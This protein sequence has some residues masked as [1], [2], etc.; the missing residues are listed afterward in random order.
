[1][2]GSAR[3]AVHRRLM[4]R[5]AATVGAETGRLDAAA[6]AAAVERCCTCGHVGAC[7]DWLEDHADG[8]EAAPGFC[9]NRDLMSALRPEAGEA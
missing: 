7:E 8:A 6:E 9:V 4:H 5:M 1:M 2:D 3:V